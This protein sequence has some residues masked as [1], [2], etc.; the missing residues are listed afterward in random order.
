[1][2]SSSSSS[3]FL[4]KFH[5]GGVFV[6]DH[7]SYN[8]EILSEIPNVDLVTMG[9]VGFVKLLVSECSSDIKQIFYHV[10]GLDFE[11]GL[12]PLKNDADLVECIECGTKSYYVL[13]IYV[14]HSVFDLHDATA[15][16]SQQNV[17]TES[18]LEDDYN[19][20]DYNSSEESDTASVDHLSEGE[21]EVF[22]ARTSKPDPAPRRKASKMFDEN[23]LSRIYKGLPSDEYVEKDVAI[24]DQSANDNDNLGDQWPIHDPSIKWKLMRP[25]LGE[26]YESPDQLKRALTFYALGN[27]YQLYYD[28]NNPRRHWKVIPS[29]ESRFEVRNGFEGFKVDKRLRT[30]TCRAWQL[31]G[32][33]CQHALAAIYFLHRDPKEYVSNW[34]KKDMFVAAYNHYIEGM[35]G[36]GQWP[37][38]QY[39]KP[40]PPIK[41]RM[42]GRPPHKRQMDASEGDGNRTKGS[43]DPF[44]GSASGGVRTRGG[45]ARGGSARG[46]SA[47]GGSARGGSAR[48]GSARG[49]STRGGSTR[50]GSVKGGSTRGWSASGSTPTKEMSASFRTPTRDGSASYR[51]PTRDGSARVRTPT[52]VSHV[53]DSV[54]GG[55]VFKTING[56]TV[57]SRGRGDGSK[58]SAYPHGIRPIGF[59]VSWDPIDGEP[60]Y[61]RM[62]QMVIP[63]PAWPYEGTPADLLT[64]NQADEI[65]NTS[66]QPMPDIVEPEP[67]EVEPKQA[68]PEEVEHEQLVI[69]R[70]N[71]VIRRRESERIKQILFKKPPQPG[72][73]LTPDDAMVLE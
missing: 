24:S 54:C 21:E 43:S 23:L 17:D 8:F 5:R 58:S 46:G 62:F 14:S 47:R 45:S 51:T 26:K 13:H 27:G 2:A 20:F 63:V 68:E 19:I 1:M 71:P 69:R 16:T 33:P 37:T 52:S 49:G 36:M 72:P 32:I 53:G 4:I 73:G 22:V 65:P 7:F 67:E 34:Y 41:R 66:S 10:S 61:T 31:S 42:P 57:R 25:Q 40:L 30:C 48:G 55:F 18:D 50:G 3:T 11:L 6:R 59:G 35:N 9:Y 28:V 12:K 38:T 29:G 56:K 60:M 44:G 64:Q 15:I 70:R 39:Q